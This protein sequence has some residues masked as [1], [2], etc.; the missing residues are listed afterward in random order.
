MLKIRLTRVG[1]RNSPVFRLVVAEKARAVKRQNIEILGLYNPG[2]ADNKFQ[3]NKERVLFWISKGAQPSDT[4]NNLLCDFGVLPKN[5]K[6]KKTFGKAQKKKD[7]KAEKDKKPESPAVETP[8]TETPEVS[9]EESKD[10]TEKKKESTTQ[11]ADR[12]K[13]QNKSEEIIQ[14]GAV[15]APAEVTDVGAVSE[16]EGAKPVVEELPIE[17]TVINNNEETAPTVDTEEAQK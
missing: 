3:A 15:E 16:I 14:D 1:K 9:A 5:Q 11:T 17:E 7:I 12:E 10:I 4:A 6:I 2:T 8:T 13:T